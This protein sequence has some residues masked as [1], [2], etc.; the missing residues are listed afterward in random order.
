MKEVVKK[1]TRTI[2][3]LFGIG[4]ESYE[5]LDD[6]V[7]KKKSEIKVLPVDESSM[8]NLNL[9]YSVLS[10]LDL[11]SVRIVLIGD[12]NQLSPIGK[13]LPFINL[14]KFMPCQFLAVSK[15]AV[16]GSNITLSSDIINNFSENDNW[17]DLES[18]DDFFLMKVESF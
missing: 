5:L 9:M 2:N 7:I 11:D 8:I 3:S 4:N 18:K 10:K 12:A 17:K 15:R 6:S 14:L 16:E 1:P 13:G